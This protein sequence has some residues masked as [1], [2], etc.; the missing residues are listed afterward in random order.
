MILSELLSELNKKYS[1]SIA[2]RVFLFSEQSLLADSQHLSVFCLFK[3]YFP[4]H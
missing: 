2:I 1:E 3:L 4:V